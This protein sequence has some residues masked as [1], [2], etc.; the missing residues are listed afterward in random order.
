MQDQEGTQSLLLLL[1]LIL[2]LATGKNM[3][4]VIREE[5]DLSAD[6]KHA[7]PLKLRLVVL[8]KAHPSPMDTIASRLLD[9]VTSEEE[10]AIN[11]RNE[12]TVNE[13]QSITSWIWLISGITITFILSGVISAIGVVMLMIC[14]EL[15]LEHLRKLRNTRAKTP[16]ALFSGDTQSAAEDTGTRPFSPT[17]SPAVP[18]SI[19]R[20]LLLK[21]TESASDEAKKFAFGK[22]VSSSSVDSTSSPSLPK[23]ASKKIAEPFEEDSI[24]LSR[25]DE[26]IS[27]SMTISRDAFNASTI[28]KVQSSWSD[29]DKERKARGSTDKESRGKESKDKESKDKESKDKE[30]KDKET[31][32]KESKGKESKE[33]GSKENNTTLKA[34]KSLFA[35]LSGSKSK[36]QLKKKMP[37]EDLASATKERSH[38]KAKKASDAK[39]GEQMIQKVTEATVVVKK[40]PEAANKSGVEAKDQVRDKPETAMTDKTKTPWT[41]LN[42]DAATDK[43]EQQQGLDKNKVQVSE[44]KEGKMGET[45]TRGGEIDGAEKLEAETPGAV[46]LEAAKLGAEIP[47]RS[48]AQMEGEIMRPEPNADDKRGDEPDE[49]SPLQRKE[50]CRPTRGGTE[51]VSVLERSAT[52][53]EPHPEVTIFKTCLP[54]KP[55]RRP[56]KVD[57]I[58]SDLREFQHPGLIVENTSHWKIAET[59]RRSEAPEEGIN[60]NKNTVTQLPHS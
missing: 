26:S 55:S 23:T 38:Q 41:E 8:Q 52:M 7:L 16:W 32:D 5:G 54:D 20:E 44:R 9:L 25:D 58:G 42:V 19:S 59:K 35:P 40:E 18:K 31:K 4:G 17:L 6:V 48:G 2:W 30:I 29:N 60:D 11:R 13:K 45:A 34:L 39:Q 43:K 47:G 28:T 57:F 51:S 12:A 53:N 50:K 14:L 46:K 10:E 56:M 33:R 21:D 1:L 27:E 3:A 49:K 22:N 15:F 36:P 24:S 37:S